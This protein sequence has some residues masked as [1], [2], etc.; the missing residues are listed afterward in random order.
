VVLNWLGIL[1]AFV[2]QRAQHGRGKECG[3]L[4]DSSD[5]TGG[6]PSVV[7]PGLCSFDVM[8]ALP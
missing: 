7:L 6:Y 8:A 4:A 3:C 2:R 5:G 1:N